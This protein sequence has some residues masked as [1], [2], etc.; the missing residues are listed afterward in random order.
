MHKFPACPNCGRTIK[1]EL[2]SGAYFNV[3]QCK[4][5]N[6]FFCKECGYN[7]GKDCPSCGHTEKRV[8]GEVYAR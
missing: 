4:K 2:F 8:G 5:C 3:Y 7:S 6:S 1:N